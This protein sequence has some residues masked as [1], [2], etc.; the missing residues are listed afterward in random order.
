MKIQNMLLAFLCIGCLLIGC[1][2]SKQ[3]NED[4]I[5]HQRK[6]PLPLPDNFDQ[7][8]D[9]LFSLVNGEKFH[10]PRA[11]VRF[12]EHLLDNG[13]PEDIA[14]VERMIPGILSG[15][16]TDPG[17]PHY[18]AFR[19]EIEM[20]AV[21]DLNAVQFLLHSLIRIIINH[22]DKLQ[23]ET[24]ENI[25]RSIRLGLVNIE[26]IDVGLK[27]TNIALKDINN[28]CLGGE[29]LGDKAFAERGYNKLKRWVDFTNQS[30]GTYEFNSTPYTAVALE[31]LHMLQKNVKDPATK[32][33]A[34]Q[35]LYRVSLGAALHMHSPTQK[36][37]GPHGRAYH[38]SVTGEEGSYRLDREQLN[39]FR[40]WIAKG[41]V[42]DWLEPLL[43][44]E[45]LDDQIIETVGI[46][47]GMSTSTFKADT[48]SF[49]VASR[50]MF[51]QDNRY[52][53]WQTN[54]FSIHYQR[55]GKE[56]AGSIYTRYLTNDHW[57]GYFAPGT[58]RGTTGLLPDE[59]HFQGV[60]DRNRAIGLY[61]PRSMGALDH[62]SSAKSV[63]A[64]PRWDS[65]EDKIWTANGEVSSFPQEVPQSE[66]VVFET[67]SIYLAVKPFSLTNLGQGARVQLN[68]MSDGTL[69]LELY[70]YQGVAKT[71]WELAWPGAFY[72]GQ[73]KNGFYSE[74][75]EKTEYE[76]AVTFAELVKR[77][78]ITD[79]SDHRSTYSGI[80]S[81]K[82]TVS[83]ERDGRLL[84]MEVDLFEWLKP[85]KRWDHDG[86]KGWPMLES[87]WAVQD[88]SG[89][90]KVN[91]NTLTCGQQPAWLYASPD[92]ATVV[93]SYQGDSPE[94]LMLEMEGAKIEIPQ[95]SS[96]L[97][98]WRNGEVTIE[99]FG[100]E[101]TPIL[102]GGELK[103]LKTY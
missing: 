92:N 32:L 88:R 52:I 15:Q 67:G 47:D 6:R 45:V 34:K 38:S 93:V 17:S 102:E 59:G 16:V 53:A 61:A 64:I 46:E 80:E 13:T 35:M 2:P 19:W 4:P 44:D 8:L 89:Q 5:L 82:W 65:K 103:E 86:D 73:P 7:E 56:I 97:V 18:G 22:E 27:Y 42:P 26:K 66:V 14:L 48:Y 81:Q 75:A 71:F 87:D 70:N 91:G 100:M 74:I 58:G 98:I 36:W 55:P 23:E 99:A 62:Y 10:G 40:K 77:G 3:A 78:E 39:T 25:K 24:V 84:G 69:V 68:K 49:G 11:S 41:E 51:N 63:I 31:V 50:S 90:I 20:E 72:Q 1:E 85:A 60:Q 94:P 33:L 79:F 96:G 29:L 37:A 28:S 21:E 101:G 43:T 57:L 12:S 54:S 76:S 30:G 9:M 83:Y 95:I